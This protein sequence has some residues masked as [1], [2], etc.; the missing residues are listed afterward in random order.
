MIKIGLSVLGVLAV[1]VMTFLVI[2]VMPNRNGVTDNLAGIETRGLP[3]HGVVIIAPA[4]P[5]YEELMSENL[6]KT[7][8]IDVETF[9]RHSVF[10]VNN[11]GQSV[12]ASIVKWE[13]LQPDGRSV[14]HNRGHGSALTVVSN[15]K[16]AQLME[17]IIPNGNQ[18]FSLIELSNNSNTRFRMG[19]GI[20]IARQISES[21]KVSVSVD[22]V[23]FVDGTFVGPDT[24]NYFERLKAEAEARIEVMA[25]IAQALSGDSEAMKRIELLAD[26]KLDGTQSA[27]GKGPSEYQ[28]MKQRYAKPIL[29]SRKKLGDKAVLEGINAELSKPRVNLRK[30]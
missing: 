17:D 6:K 12:A 8:G 23:L 26:G 11:S 29:A 3:E 24:T 15:G 28:F 16:P 21:V 7:P 27:V 22:G 2:G 14:S 20:D 25:Q 19:G 1:G 10:V 30:L 5:A 9:K 4:H 13:L 18:L